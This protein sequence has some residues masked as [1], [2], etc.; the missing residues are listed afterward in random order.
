MFNLLKSMNKRRIAT[1]LLILLLSLLLISSVTYA[2]SGS[3]IRAC[4]K[5][6]KVASIGANITCGKDQTLL[7]WNIMGPP[8][9]QG[10]KGPMGPQGEQGPPGPAGTS[11]DLE[12]RIK[13]ALA[14]FKIA[15][16]CL[17]DTDGDG[18]YDRD[19]ER[20]GTDPTNPDTDGDGLNDFIEDE[21]I[22]PACHLCTSPVN[23]DSDHDGLMDG[24]EVH[25]F[26]T[27]PILPDTDFDGFN[28]GEEVL[29]G[30]DPLNPDSHP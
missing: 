22:F 14:G 28:D 12:W 19:E 13:D 30:T 1:A 20:I 8:G 29:A 10:E 27:D 16:E 5:D 15:P 24:D 23:A 4:V 21:R 11:C 9:P 25:I 2:Q 26:N 18:I 3:T 17:I 6:G 7:E